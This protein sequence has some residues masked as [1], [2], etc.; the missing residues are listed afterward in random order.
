M[1]L[2][3][4]PDDSTAPRVCTHTLMFSEPARDETAFS[5]LQQTPA[6]GIEEEKEDHA[7]SHDVH[8][9]QHHHC[10]VI[11]T[12]AMAQAAYGVPGSE[13]GGEGRNEQLQR[14]TI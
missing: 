3:G 1:C 12:P 6:I 2:A 4:L 5:R 10:A 11:E 14:G 9:N 13:E 7:K 8:I